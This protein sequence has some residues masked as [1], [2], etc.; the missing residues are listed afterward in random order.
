MIV[1]PIYSDELYKHKNL[2]KWHSFAWTISLCF[3]WVCSICFALNGYNQHKAFSSLIFGGVTLSMLCLV[4]TTVRL[5]KTIEA[6]DR[7]LV[8]MMKAREQ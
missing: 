6:I 4:F 3:V 8:K 2:P 5:E 7:D 1:T